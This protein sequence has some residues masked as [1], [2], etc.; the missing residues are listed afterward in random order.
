MA[1]VRGKVAVLSGGH[2]G[3]ATATVAPTISIRGDSDSYTYPYSLYA[4]SQHTYAYGQHTYAYGQHTALS[5]RA[6]WA[7][8]CRRGHG[9]AGGDRFVE[10]RPVGGAQDERVE[11]PLAMILIKAVLTVVEGYGIFVAVHSLL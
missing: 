6:P 9:Y 10:A 8:L 3:E 5:K 2:S 11:L 7:W 1:M 4:Y